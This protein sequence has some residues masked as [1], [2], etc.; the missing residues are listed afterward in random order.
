MLL[1]GDIQALEDLTYEK[2]RQFLAKYTFPSDLPVICFHTEASRSPGWLATMSQIAQADLPWL[3]GGASSE[4]Q[5]AS[6]KLP[7]AVPLAAAMAVC[8]L[9]LELRYGEKSD[10]L[11]M[12]KDAEVPGSIVVRLEKKLDHGWMVY[13]PARKDPLEPDAAQMCEALLTLVLNHEKW[14]RHETTVTPQAEA[15]LRDAQGAASRVSSK[16]RFSWR[17]RR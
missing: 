10:G 11:V 1:Q 15:S 12:R 9:H 16:K 17:I 14:K 3:P 7:V 4:Q 8:A 5:V 6:A 13:S 2:R